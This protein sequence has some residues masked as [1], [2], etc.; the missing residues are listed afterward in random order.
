MGY[1]L[2]FDISLD[3][4]DIG[5][6][7]LGFEPQFI[8]WFKYSRYPEEIRYKLRKERIYTKIIA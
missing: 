2:W 6:I 3:I 5:L 8:S 1:G 7:G 4:F